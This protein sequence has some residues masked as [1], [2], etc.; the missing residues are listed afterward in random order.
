MG[1]DPNYYL[2]DLIF[3]EG[4]NTVTCDWIDLTRYFGPMNDAANGTFTMTPV[5]IGHEPDIE[6]L[7]NDPGMLQ[8]TAPA[9][10]FPTFNEVEMEDRT[11][12]TQHPHV[13]GAGQDETF[14]LNE[15]ND[16]IVGQTGPAVEFDNDTTV[17]DTHP[18]IATPNMMVLWAN[19]TSTTF[20]LPG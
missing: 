12:R 14:L 2:V 10:S 18:T 1:P 15:W 8:P 6:V 9:G 16:S 13:L 11:N 5:S 7:L 19:N 17:S 4:S 3:H 20:F